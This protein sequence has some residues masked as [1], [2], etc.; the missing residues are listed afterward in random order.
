V[1]AAITAR[2]TVSADIQASDACGNV[3]FDSRVERAAR[4]DKSVNALA[5]DETFLRM[6]D[7]W[8]EY[9]SDPKKKLAPLFNIIELAKT[10]F[11]SLEKAATTLIISL[12]K[13]KEAKRIMNDC[14]I[15]NSRHPGRS[16]VSPKPVSNEDRHVCEQIAEAIVKNYRELMI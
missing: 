11:G 14:G 12:T 7:Y 6:T 2:A 3:I 10:K 16:P 15:E 9:C 13:I 1:S 4:I 8:L 5:Q